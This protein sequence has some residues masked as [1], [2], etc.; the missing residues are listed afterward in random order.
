M[1]LGNCEYGNFSGLGTEMIAMLR[2]K[3]YTV[4]LRRGSGTEKR[5]GFMADVY[6]TEIPAKCLLL[7]LCCK[8]Y[9]SE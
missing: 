7:S 6:A 9:L 1:H 8:V 4:R 2:W 5:A 3:F